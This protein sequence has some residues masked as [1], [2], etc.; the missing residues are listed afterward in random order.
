GERRPDARA[1]G[2]R[3]R[4][5]RQPP[6]PPQGD[7][8]APPPP[9]SD[10]RRDR[11]SARHHPENGGEP[12]RSRP[13]GPA[14]Q[15]DRLPRGLSPPPAGGE[16]LGGGAGEPCHRVTTPKRHESW[17]G[18]R[19]V[20]LVPPGPLPLRRVRRCRGG[21]VRGVARPASGSAPRV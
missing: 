11:G 4:G 20:R 12:P 10:L 18:E 21:G 17:H 9:R 15:P 2:S 7:L 14:E 5:D 13:Q 6:S 16:G 1:P 3:R 8:P 19:R